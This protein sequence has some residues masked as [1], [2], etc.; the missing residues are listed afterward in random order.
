MTR[1]DPSAA[2]AAANA[3]MR[4]STLHMAVNINCFNTST[5]QRYPSANSSAAFKQ[6]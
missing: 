3:Q 2:A 5:A 1:E 4:P 6:F